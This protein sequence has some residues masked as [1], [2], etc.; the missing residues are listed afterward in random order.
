MELVFDVIRVACRHLRWRVS[1]HVQWSGERAGE[2]EESG[3]GKG[4]GAGRE[5]H[6]ERR[7]TP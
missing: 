7:E 4:K 5:R 2:D 6:G 3:G 1:V